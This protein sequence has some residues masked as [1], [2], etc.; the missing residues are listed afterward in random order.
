MRSS[1]R[2]CQTPVCRRIASPGIRSARAT[3]HLRAVFGIGGPVASCTARGPLF[4][5]QQSGRPR[6]SKP[7]RLWPKM[8][9]AAFHCDMSVTFALHGL[10]ATLGT[11]SEFRH[12]NSGMFQHVSVTSS[13]CHANLP[14]AR[15]QGGSPASYSR[16]GQWMSLTYI[17]VYYRTNTWGRLSRSLAPLP[18]TSAKS[19][20][21]PAAP[22]SGDVPEPS[23]HTI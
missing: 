22:L 13:L 10:Q 15:A 7:C 4:G 6:R 11:H 19:D 16:W 5:S 8:S 1:N 2:R 20:E 12:A 21:G 14:L 3:V 23:A 18:G 9:R 17:I